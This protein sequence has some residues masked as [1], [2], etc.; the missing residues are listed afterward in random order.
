MLLRGCLIDEN[1]NCISCSFK[2]SDQMGDANCVT[3][4]E[5]IFT[6]FPYSEKWSL[7][8]LFMTA[9]AFTRLSGYKTSYLEKASM[10]YKIYLIETSLVG[11]LISLSRI[12]TR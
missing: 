5:T 3:W 4:S 11:N 8:N 9:F 7:L 6:G 12:T 10:V 1:T 2:K